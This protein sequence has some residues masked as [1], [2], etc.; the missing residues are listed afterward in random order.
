MPYIGHIRV[1]DLTTLTVLRLYNPLERKGLSPKSIHDIH[2]MLHGMLDMTIN[3]RIS[4]LWSI[5]DSNW[6]RGIPRCPIL[7][8][9]VVVCCHIIQIRHTL[10]Q[11]IPPG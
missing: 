11:G 1:R 9:L 5:G 8:Y 10:S 7:C 4:A 2:G 3:A 6:L